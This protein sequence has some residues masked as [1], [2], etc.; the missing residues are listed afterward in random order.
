MSWTR[1]AGIIAAA[2]GALFLLY[3]FLWSTLLPPEL[4]GAAWWTAVLRTMV[5]RGAGA[6]T[7]I[8]TV[9]LVGAIILTLRRSPPRS[10]LVSI[11]VAAAVAVIIVL[12]VVLG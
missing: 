12:G 10:L 1:T 7:A 3:I 9:A 6:G 2:F 8:G 11:I 5:S 4:T